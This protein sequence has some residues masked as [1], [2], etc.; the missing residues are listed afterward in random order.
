MAN[1]QLICGCES[2]KYCKSIW[3]VPAGSCNS[4]YWN[5]CFHGL[6]A[7]SWSNSGARQGGLHLNLLVKKLGMLGWVWS[8][9]D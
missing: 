9:P 2:I 1:G 3:P 7:C 6:V 8:G 4:T 5:L